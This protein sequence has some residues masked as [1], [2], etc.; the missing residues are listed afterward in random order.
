L[1]RINIRTTRHLQTALLSLKKCFQDNFYLNAECVCDLF[2]SSSSV[3]KIDDLVSRFLQRTKNIKNVILF[4]I[5]HGGFLHNRE[6]YLAIR[7][8]KKLKEHLTGLR[9]SALAHTL[10]GYIGERNL[11]IFLDC[12]FAGEAVE[13]FQTNDLAKIVETKTYYALPS[14]GTALLVA[15]SKEEPAISPYGSKYTMFSE[16]LLNVLENGVPNAGDMISLHQ[17]A[18][19]TQETIKSKHGLAGVRPEVHSPRQRGIDIAGLRVFPNLSSKK[20]AGKRHIDI[21][22]LFESIESLKVG[23]IENRYSVSFDFFDDSFIWAISEESYDVSRSIEIVAKV[24]SI[25]KRMDAHAILINR[26]NLILNSSAF[27]FWRSLLDEACLQGHRTLAVLLYLIS[28]DYAQNLRDKS[29]LL[30]DAL[31]ID[32]QAKLGG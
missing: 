14:A 27:E 1:E 20:G 22:D 19:A 25:L 7:S 8:T 12:C 13:Q 10:N 6:Y 31:K 24:N 21:G 18:Q 5:G 15:A 28:S 3:I 11:F 2:D 30:I 16:A 29:L 32:Y 17:I 26:G 23:E 4:Y 9:I